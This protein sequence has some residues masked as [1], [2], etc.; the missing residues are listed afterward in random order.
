MRGTI[1]VVG[2]QGF[3]EAQDGAVDIARLERQVPE[4]HPRRSVLGNGSERVFERFPRLDS[5]F[6]ANQGNAA[7]VFDRRALR[8]FQIRAGTQCVELRQ[9]LISAAQRQQA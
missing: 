4:I 2:F 6:Q 1:G 8:R 9:R 5:A 3:L 7:L